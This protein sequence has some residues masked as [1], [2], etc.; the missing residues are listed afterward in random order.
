MNPNQ[1]YQRM[2]APW[3]MEYI[4]AP[5]E[6]GCF[7][8]RYMQADPSQDGANLVL[9]RGRTCWMVL[10]RYPYNGGHLMVAPVRHVAELS[11]LGDEEA[12]E[13]M[14]LTLAAERLMKQVLQ[15]QGVNVGM[16]IGEAAGAGLKEHIHMHVVPRWVGDTNFMPVLGHVRVMPQALDELW[17]ELK[18]HL[19]SVL[20]EAVVAEV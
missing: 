1:D 6:E 16:N 15:A 17:K 5:K 9:H 20:P 8:C 11:A 13:L 2:W 14:R 10:N 4:R 3:R 18:A 7:L 19:P 12:L